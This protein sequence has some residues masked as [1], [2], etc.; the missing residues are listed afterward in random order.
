M[1]ILELIQKTTAYFEKAGVPSPRL[2]VELLLA[3]VLCL[4]RMELYLQFERVLKDSE[5]EALRPMVKR[6]S[7]REPLQHILGSVEFHGLQ[8]NVGP[9]ALI[10][11]PETEI[12]VETALSKMGK[13]SNVDVLDLG[14]GTGAIILAI[15]QNRPNA[16]CM[17]TDISEA[18]L[19]LARINAEKNKLQERVE[20]RSGNLFEPL[21]TGEQFDLIVSNPPYIPS[22]EISTL[23]PEVQRDPIN[24]LDGGPDGLDIIRKII[25]SSPALLKSDGFLIMEI[26]HDQSVAVLELLKAAGFR[27][28]ESVNDLQGYARI[29]T[30]QKP[31]NSPP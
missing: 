26:G 17:A 7:S 12:L 23:Q 28:T 25:S 4:K 31:S 5:L 9:D 1:T 30:G 13:E 15:A 6:R 11:R 21:K 14:T 3:H 8:L 16:Q 18:A 29:V 22:A 24:A 10:P 19:K 2:D 27:N 20:F